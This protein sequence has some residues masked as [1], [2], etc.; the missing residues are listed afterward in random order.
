[1]DF[2]SPSNEVTTYTNPT[3]YDSRGTLVKIS[4][5]TVIVASNFLCQFNERN[6]DDQKEWF[7]YEEGTPSTAFFNSYSRTFVYSKTE[8][9]RNSSSVALIPIDAFLEHPDDMTTSES[10]PGTTTSATIFK[11][12]CTLLFSTDKQGTFITLF[13][14]SLKK[15]ALYV[16]H[17]L[18]L[19]TI[20]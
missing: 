3:C 5:D 18:L 19:T 20:C 9:D 4:D 10:V 15:D 13:S 8:Y 14:R 12:Y 6:P 1:V 2:D 17:T 16:V 7:H 11:D